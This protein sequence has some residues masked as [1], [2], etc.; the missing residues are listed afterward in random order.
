MQVLLDK[1]SQ[2][3]TP[4]Q[5]RQIRDSMSRLSAGYDSVYDVSNSNLN[6]LKSEIEKER[7]RQKE[8]VKV[9]LFRIFFQQNCELFTGGP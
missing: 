2:Y 9:S 8:N 6:R 5:T 3:L 7:H 4:E 1:R